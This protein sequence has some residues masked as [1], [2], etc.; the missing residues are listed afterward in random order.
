MVEKRIY[1]SYYARSYDHPNAIGISASVPKHFTGPH[2]TVLAPSWELLD[3]YKKGEMTKNQ[4]AE[5][6]VA[7]LEGRKLTPQIVYDSIPN[8]A[9]LLCYEKPGDFCHRRV[10]AEWLEN[11]L[12]VTIKEW[13]SDE[14]QKKEALV[15]DLLK[16]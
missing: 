2:M 8:A 14:E 6:Y 4:Y 16:F 5:E 12:N 7:L 11:D 13:L 3:K 10:L 15:D 9:I 1:T